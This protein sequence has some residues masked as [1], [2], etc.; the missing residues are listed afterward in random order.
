MNS[1]PIITL[2]V[3][4][5]RHS[6]KIALS[7]YTAQ[8]DSHL[9]EAIE[10]FCTPENLRRI[11]ETEAAQTLDQVLREEVKRWFITGDGRQVIRAAV[12]KKL[13]D[14]ETWTPLDLNWKQ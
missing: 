8:L 4:Q 5:I 7:E 1:L 9:Q 2:S 11:V 6:M 10:R 14:D 3:D 12:E 13:S